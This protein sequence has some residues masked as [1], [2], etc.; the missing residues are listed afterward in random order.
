MPK[1]KIEINGLI[2]GIIAVI[3]F[4]GGVFFMQSTYNYCKNKHIL[5]SDSSLVK[6]LGIIQQ[7]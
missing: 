5:S 6:I 3:Q 7:F 1:S 2:E 4:A